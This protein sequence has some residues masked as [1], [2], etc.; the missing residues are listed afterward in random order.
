MGFVYDFCHAESGF[1]SGNPIQNSGFQCSDYN[2][3]G[4]NIKIYYI[5][6]IL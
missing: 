3:N 5:K 6:N 4:F 1:P 2:G